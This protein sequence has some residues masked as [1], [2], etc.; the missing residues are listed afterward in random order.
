MVGAGGLGAEIGEGLVRK[1][2]GWIMILDDD[3][4]ELSNLNRQKFYR[5][6]L[7]K[8][9]ATSL[10]RNLRDEGAMGTVLMP[11]EMRFQDALKRGV[12]L[13]CDLVICGVDNN[14]TRTEVARYCYKRDIPAIFTA[15]SLEADHGYVMVQEPGEA[16][17]GCALP[18]AARD[19]EEPC[20]G[21]PAVKD[22]LKLMGALVIYAVDSLFMDRPR[23]WNYREIYLPDG[24]FDQ[25]SVVKKKNKCP[26]CG[27][28]KKG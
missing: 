5:R 15:V 23:R 16:C 14:P 1:G 17:W 27:G 6:D 4:V 10:A 3:T 22:V 25:A 12:D 11:Y 2:V 28:K 26:I 7:Y 9:K 20:P 8:N 24:E 13:P 21:S 19:Q 18:Y